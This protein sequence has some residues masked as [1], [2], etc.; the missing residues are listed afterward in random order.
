MARLGE[1]ADTT[2]GK[3]LDKAKST[4]KYPAK[5]LRNINVQ[6]G[7]I[8]QEDVLFM[9][10]HPDERE[11]FALRAGDLLVCEGGEVGRC[12][13]WQ[14]GGDEYVSFQKALHRI[15]PGGALAVEYLRY[16]LEFL[17]DSGGL[18]KYSTGS[19]IKHLPQQR[20]REIP[21]ALPPIREQHR[22]VEALDDHISRVDSAAKTLN[23]ARMRAVRLRKSA[24][25]QAMSGKL[26]ERNP[27]DQP[28]GELIRD[29]RRIVQTSGT[30]K[31]KNA[32]ADAIEGNLSIPSHWQILPLGSLCLSIEYGTSSKTGSASSPDDVPVLRMGNIQDGGINL[33]SLKYLPADHPEVKKRALADGDLLF[34]RTNSAELVGKA[35]VYR[36][37]MGRATFA[38]Y[39]IRCRLAT[40]IEPDWV[41]LC[42]NSVEG[43]RY[44]NSVVTQQVGQAN[45]NGSK[46]GAFPI[47]VPPHGEQLR[48]LAA[49]RDWDETFQR[50]VG[51]ANRA[52]QRAAHLRKSLLTYAFAGDLVPQDPTDE[53]VSVLLAQI[54]ASQQVGAKVRRPRRASIATEPSPPPAPAGTAVTFPRST[55]QQEFE[56]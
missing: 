54:R 8:D 37:S 47:P 27:F 30:V 3:M 51:A 39:L 11:F 9:D 48:I 52:L 16:Y 45:V 40:G 50:S 42:V 5:Y 36:S 10:I 22:I 43:R 33:D 23:D 38:S 31:Q 20:L 4:G 29:V 21:V 55:V 28:V 7:R 13:I 56:F 41:S 1:V 6:W 32:R 15:R 24:V 35:A 18:K 53:P 26:A 19:T 14:G 25:Q 34:N 12:A 44:I 2:L 49:I 46:L 17:S